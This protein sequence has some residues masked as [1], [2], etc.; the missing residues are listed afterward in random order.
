MNCPRIVLLALAVTVALGTGAA[1]A[2]T[3]SDGFDVLLQVNASC[4][5]QAT[6]H[7]FGV[8]DRTLGNVGASTLTVNCTVLTPYSVGIDGCTH[9]SGVADRKMKL[10]TGSTLASY[11]LRC[12][13]ALQ[14]CF[15]NWGNSPSV[16]TLDLIG[17]E[18]DVPLPVVGQA[19]SARNLPAGSY[20]DVCLAVIT[21]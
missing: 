18:I 9:G 14:G 2:G 20:K 17:T 19:A 11:S 10:T 13:D 15:T 1:F 6:D 16:D 5:I 3:A 8:Y 7:D 12:A 21:F 4:G